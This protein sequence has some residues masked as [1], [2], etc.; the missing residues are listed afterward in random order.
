MDP[1]KPSSDQPISVAEEITAFSIWAKQLCDE[2]FGSTD[3]STALHIDVSELAPLDPD[4]L[5]LDSVET[6]AYGLWIIP[7]TFPHKVE[8]FWECFRRVVPV[9]ERKGWTYKLVEH[10]DKMFEAAY[11]ATI[12]SSLVNR[13]DFVKTR[14]SRAVLETKIDFRIAEMMLINFQVHGGIILISSDAT[15]D[16]YLAALALHKLRT[17]HC[18]LLFLYT[19]ISTGRKGI[20]RLRDQLANKRAS[21]VSDPPKRVYGPHVL[22]QQIS[23]HLLFLGTYYQSGF[24]TW[25]REGRYCWDLPELELMARLHDL[26]IKALQLICFPASYIDDPEFQNRKISKQYIELRP[27]QRQLEA[28][29]SMPLVEDIFG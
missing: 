9:D 13:S 24:K 19:K 23:D 10:R 6:L 21:W 3:L 16:L 11:E 12:L 29:P 2:S 27:S 15:D 5:P 18:D 7:I 25:I 22:V 4:P 1:E 20:R 26:C 17:C 8:D 14:F 28:V